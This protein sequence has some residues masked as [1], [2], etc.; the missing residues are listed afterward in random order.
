MHLVF[1]NRSFYPDLEATGQYLTELAEDLI[2][3]GHEVTVVC[4]RSLHKDL[5]EQYLIK[6]ERYKSINIIRVS[7]T[8]LPKR[9]LLF[10]IINLSIYFLLAFLSGFLIRKNPDIVIAQTDPPVMGLI[11]IFFSKWYRS[12]FIYSCKDLYPDVGIVTGRLT[13]PILNWLLE[14]IN[15]LSFTMADLVIV[16]GEDMKK[17][18]CGKGVKESKIEIVHDWADTSTIYPVKREENIFRNENDFDKYF[19][20]MYSGNIGLTQGLD[21]I[22]E[23]AELLRSNNKIKFILIGEGADKVKLQKKVQDLKLTNV[24]FFPYQPKESLKYSLGAP[25]IHIITFIKGL[26]GAMVPCKI[27]G[28]LATGTP[29]IAWIDSESLIYN[30]ARNYKCGIAVTPG[31]VK[32]MAHAI[33]WAMNH[34]ETLADMSKRCRKTAEELF[35]R[36]ISTKKFNNLVNALKN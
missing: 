31:N 11:G 30:I 4:G 7:G 26:A 28:I 23:V 22:I 9:F 15:F 18:V 10:R 6:R 12:K 14:K 2:S 35:N 21:K 5:D 33:K 17:R 19:T 32:S 29:F 27:Y 25:D 13:N 20:V 16:L 3:Y 34:K 1:F 24:V 36:K 8:T